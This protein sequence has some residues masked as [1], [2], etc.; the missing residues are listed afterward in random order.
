MFWKRD[1]AQAS[2]PAAPASAVASAANPAEASDG[3]RGADLY[4]EHL[5]RIQDEQDWQQSHLRHIIT[6]NASNF[7]FWVLCAISCAFS[8][9]NGW[10]GFNSTLAEGMVTAVLIGFMYSMVEL[11][12]PISAQ[13]MSWEGQGTSKWVL[14]IAGGVAYIGAVLFSL[15]ILQGKF[16]STADS[17]S[18]RTEVVADT[19]QGASAEYK[20]LEK[21]VAALD[22][23]VTRTAAAITAEID[24]VLASPIGQG[25]GAKTL[26]EVTAS[27]SGKRTTSV[28]RERC[29]QVD[30]LKRELSVAESIEAARARMDVMRNTLT[31]AVAKGETARTSDVAEKALAK[32]T[33]INFDNIRL[34]KASVIAT[35][36]ALV[37]HLLWAVYGAAANG[38]IA[39]AR[40][41]T[42]AM[43]TLTRA[44][45]RTEGAAER[46]RR[47]LEANF[48]AAQTNRMGLFQAAAK[49]AA[50]GSTL[51]LNE[52]PAVEQ[53][54]SYLLAQCILG[55]QLYTS[56]GV[57][58]D[59][60]VVWAKSNGA[61]GLSIDRMQVILRECGLKLAPD[62]RV[63]GVALRRS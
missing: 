60:Y 22:G 58:H 52:Q 11:T 41:R 63:L 9:L 1:V 51:R 8:L 34:F 59:D 50:S 49:T 46:E 44:V 4:R 36:A 39:R 30:S 42:L 25:K 7:A 3:L 16:A 10:Y 56:L 13:F 29:A 38:T 33:G 2:Y 48:Q 27:C 24:V 18:A 47:E 26:R 40:T 17:I 6:H 32:A 54:K 14:R 43:R 12:V 28:E 61:L 31:T 5:S 55:E 37:T 15:T 45:E 57:L 23:K 53:V 20:R 62:G 35:I 19:L 21:Q